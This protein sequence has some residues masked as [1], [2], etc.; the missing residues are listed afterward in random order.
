[1][2]GHRFVLG[3]GQQSQAS[4]TDRQTPTGDDVKKKKYL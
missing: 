2:Y 1:M 4:S 3:S